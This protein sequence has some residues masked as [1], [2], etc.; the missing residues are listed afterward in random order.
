MCRQVIERLNRFYTQRKVQPYYPFSASQLAGEEM[1]EARNRLAAYVGVESDELNF[2]PSTS[3]NTYVLAQAFRQMLN[4]GDAVIV[5]NQ[6][7]EANS[8]QWRKL[9]DDD[10]EIRE[11]QVDEDTG[12]LDISYLETLLDDKVKLLCFPHSSNVVAEVNPV[13]KI[14]AMARAAGA[15][16]CVD[17]VSYAPHGL[18]NIGQL[19]PDIYLF[20]AYKTWGPHQGIMVI[21][22]DLA[23]RLPNQGHFF[24][25]GTL[26]KRLTPAGPDHAQVAACAGLIDYFEIL[27]A[28]H[29]DSPSVGSSM[30][31]DIHGLFSAHE[32]ELLQP[33][34]DFAEQKNNVRLIGPKSA[35]GRAATVAMET[36]EPSL[37]VA[38][39]LAD[40]GIMVGCGHYYGLRVLKALGIDPDHGV[41][42]VSFVHYT[43]QSEVDRA[44]Q[45]LD[46]VL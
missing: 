34:L 17:G 10:I 20:S 16:T 2:G 39:K 13:A 28:H 35:A 5:T 41:L 38:K 1:D 7:H 29:F 3:Q 36:Q 43:S 6:D 27:H 24:N 31:E 19:G 37:V 8:G 33:L 11:W 22:R 21:R 46:Q 4:A 14:V 15:Y 26:F 40:L 44:I 18:P 42:R 23:Q 30:G 25:Q 32:K 9:A 45:A 12:H